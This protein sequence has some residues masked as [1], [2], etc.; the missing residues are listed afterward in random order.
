M[1]MQA[2]ETIMPEQ[3]I[4]TACK[5]ACHQSAEEQL[6]RCKECSRAEKNDQKKKVFRARG[7]SLRSGASFPSVHSRLRSRRAFSTGP[8]PQQLYFPC[9]PFGICD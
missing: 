6:R 3:K 7:R 4:T 2:G 8:N 9:V 5:K 1:K